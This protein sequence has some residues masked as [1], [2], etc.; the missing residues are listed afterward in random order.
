MQLALALLVRV[1]QGNVRYHDG[2]GVAGPVSQLWLE[3]WH[4]VGDI[5]VHD[6]W[7]AVEEGHS[8]QHVPVKEPKKTCGRGVT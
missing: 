1:L 7:E 8:Y 2:P 5:K 4:L 6:K 3:R